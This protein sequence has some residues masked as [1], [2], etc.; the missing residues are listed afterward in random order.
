M[1]FGNKTCYCLSI[2]YSRKLEGTLDGNVFQKGKGYSQC[3]QGITN[4]QTQ[5]F[6]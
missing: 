4:D 5:P 6:R 3:N 1:K 2:A